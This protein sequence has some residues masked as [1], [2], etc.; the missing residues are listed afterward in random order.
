MLLK[1]FAAALPWICQIFYL[2]WLVLQFS[3]GFSYITASLFFAAA[4]MALDTVLL[5]FCI[6]AEE[7][8]GTALFAPA[9]LVEGLNTFTERQEA[10]EAAR[11]FRKYRTYD[12]D[13]DHDQ[14]EKNEK[15]DRSSDSDDDSS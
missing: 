3:W 2:M 14:D 9:A 4:E 12:E 7:N 6:D 8:K 5:S 1:F 15:N 10:A 13:H 11:E